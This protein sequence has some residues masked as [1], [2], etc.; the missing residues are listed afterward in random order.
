MNYNILT[1]SDNAYFPF[2]KILIN[3]I[4]K[5]CDLSKINSIFVIN[6]GLSNTQIE[7][8]TN[9][10][11]KIKL[12]NTGNKTSIRTYEN[13][14]PWSKDWQTNVRS[15]TIQLYKLVEELNEPIM[16]L[17]SDMMVMSDLFRLTLVEGD[18]QVC[19]RPH[20]PVAT[21]IASYFFCVNPKKALPFIEK[22]R[23]LTQHNFNANIA[24]HNGSMAHESPALSRIESENIDKIDIKRLSES[25]VNLYSPKDLLEDTVLVHFKGFDPNRNPSNNLEESIHAHMFSRGWEEH[26]KTNKYIE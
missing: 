15:K 24:F 13:W 17:D 18:I 21:C 26:I 11:D 10:L 23:D 19:Y 4:I 22:W 20:S 14:T 3:S 9:K 1:T 16:L 2:L 25:L 5:E 7:Y 8:L 12:I 6:N